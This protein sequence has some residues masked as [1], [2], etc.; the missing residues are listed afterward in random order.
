[1]RTLKLVAVAG[2]VL[3]LAPA[4]SH[5]GKWRGKTEQGER[6]VVATSGGKVSRVTVRYLARCGDGEVL[7]SG[8]KFLPTFDVA[9]R[10]RFE[11]GGSYS[12]GLGDGERA[13]ARTYVRGKRASG[14]WS[15][16]FRVRIRVTKNGSFVTWCKLGKTG[17][18]AARVG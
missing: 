1:M 15:G 2:A 4:T 8:T 10:K 7:R 6:V 5:A 18:S 16:D 12:F 11:D 17:W 3:L 14:R 9:G 13:R